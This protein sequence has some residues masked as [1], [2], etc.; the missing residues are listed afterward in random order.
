MVTWFRSRLSELTLLTQSTGS[1]LA[2]RRRSLNASFLF[3]RP[4][5]TSCQIGSWIYAKLKN[6]TPAGVCLT[7]SLTKI[8]Y[9][10]R[11]CRVAGRNAASKK[12]GEE[13]TMDETKLCMIQ[14]NGR[15]TRDKRPSSAFVF[16]SL[17]LTR[18]FLSRH[19]C[20]FMD[21]LSLALCACV[22]VV[23]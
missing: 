16:I 5:P 19:L 8:T 13:P 7:T 17:Q 11:A 21:G 4:T 20:A 6:Y 18:L 12:E 14:I 1:H 15:A 22:A 23:D 3:E 9:K 10:I 2:R